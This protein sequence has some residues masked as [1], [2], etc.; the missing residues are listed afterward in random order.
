MD[1]NQLSDIPS[2]VEITRLEG[3]E[4]GFREAYQKACQLEA[5]DEKI[6][7]SALR[8]GFVQEHVRYFFQLD[9]KQF[10]QLIE[11]IN[12]ENQSCYQNR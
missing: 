5:T 11:Q 9:D 7:K 12:H 8:S 3:F 10:D 4:E 6:A 2:W 1:K